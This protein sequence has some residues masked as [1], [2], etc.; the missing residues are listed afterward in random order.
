MEQEIVTR[1][2]NI[3][4]HGVK[5]KSPQ[6]HYI[7]N[8]SFML[9]ERHHFPCS[10]TFCSCPPLP[11]TGVPT[12]S[13]KPTAAL[14]SMPLAGVPP[15]LSPVKLSRVISSSLMTGRVRSRGVIDPEIPGCMI[16][17][18]ARK[19]G[20]EG[21]SC[22]LRARRRRCRLRSGCSSLYIRALRNNS[23]SSIALAS[24]TLEMVR[25]RW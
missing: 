3:D 17:P 8:T 13:V 7:K 25:G 21:S 5:P 16:D 11:Y 10:S 6:N 24:I 12:L 4:G 20:R 1:I 22:K 19:T 9:H 23:G 14:P 2:A 18:P 15:C